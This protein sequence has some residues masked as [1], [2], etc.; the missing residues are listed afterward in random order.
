MS[1]MSTTTQL[2][3]VAMRIREMRE[4]LGFSVEE[5]AEKTELTLE[6]YNLY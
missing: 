1:N 5:M 4:I 3:D 6:T 2:M